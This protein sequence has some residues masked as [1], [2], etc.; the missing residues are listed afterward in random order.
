[1]AGVDAMHVAEHVVEDV[2]KHDFDVGMGGTVVPVELVHHSASFGFWCRHRGS[3]LI[4]SPRPLLALV[5]CKASE[6][7]SKVI[8]GDAETSVRVY[9]GRCGDCRARYLVVGFVPATDRGT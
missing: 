8:F 5:W 7:T 1:M 9:V 2:A 6:I 4:R 3:P